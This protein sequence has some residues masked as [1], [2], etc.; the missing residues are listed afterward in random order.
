MASI[1]DVLDINVDAM[2]DMYRVFQK[3]DLSQSQIA[4]HSLALLGY[5]VANA[6]DREAA[7]AETVKLLAIVA[8]SKTMGAFN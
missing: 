6:V 4:S 8:R 7:L 3:Y 1:K 2:R 5:H